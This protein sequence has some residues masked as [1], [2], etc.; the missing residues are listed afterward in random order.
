M[1]RAHRLSSPT[2]RNPRTCLTAKIHGTPM[3]R[4]VGI[5]DGHEHTTAVPLNHVAQ[6]NLQEMT[7]P[8][9][10]H[11]ALDFLKWDRD[12]VCTANKCRTVLAV[13]E[14]SSFP[15]TILCPM[16]IDT[17]MVTV[18]SLTWMKI[19]TGNASIYAPRQR[20]SRHSIVSVEFP[21]R[22]LKIDVKLS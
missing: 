8:R 19:P 14:R 18:G 20:I 10:V 1:R 7:F 22:H 12:T 17:D 6:T 4:T 3:A 15:Q 2:R 13:L 16:S 9:R 21:L 5:C 11:P